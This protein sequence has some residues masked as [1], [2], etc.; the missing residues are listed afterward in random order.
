MFGEVLEAFD[1]FESEPPEHGEHCIA[2]GR[3]RLWRIARVRTRLILA[4][5]Y[6]AHVVQPVL[7][8]PVF[9]RQCE[10]AFWSGFCSGQTGD[11][12]DRLDALFAAHDT[13]AGHAA[14]LGHA[15]PTRCQVV[16]DAGGGLQPAGLDPATAFIECLGLLEVRRRRPFR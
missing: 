1:G 16:G 11:G 13:L 8:P 4:A 6:V 9:T 10:Q 5:G 3:E 7:D 15:G 2:Q 14:D 12:I